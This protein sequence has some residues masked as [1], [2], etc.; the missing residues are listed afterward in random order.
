MEVC[1]V[2]VDRL[3]QPA[4]SDRLGPFLGG[5]ALHSARYVTRV[6]S[7][8][9]PTIRPARALHNGHYAP[10][11]ITFDVGEH[12]ALFSRNPITGRAELQISDE[13]VL[14]QSPYRL[15]THFDLR[16]QTVWRRQIDAHEVTITRRRSRVFGGMRQSSYTVTVDGTAVAE[17]AG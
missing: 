4:A 13:V 16:A 5:H 3:T 1:A 12:Q 8:A 9:R 14:L 10:V 15:T 7:N 6:H 17:L 11:V 2:D